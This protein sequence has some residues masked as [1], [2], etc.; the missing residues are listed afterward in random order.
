MDLIIKSNKLKF[1]IIPVIIYYSLY[2]RD[3]TVSSINVTRIFDVIFVT[4]I[5]YNYLDIKIY[6]SIN[7][8]L[9]KKYFI[10]LNLL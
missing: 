8:Y 5:H 2:S 1:L 4:T 6:K 10:N 9:I 7:F 3:N